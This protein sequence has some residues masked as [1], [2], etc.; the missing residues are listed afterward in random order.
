[1]IFQ[2]TAHLVTSGQKTQT[3]RLW[4]PDWDFAREW[5]IAPG[6]L[7]ICDC[8]YHRRSYWLLY[9]VGQKLAVQPGRGQRAIARI[10]V[11]RLWREDVREISDADVRAEG[12]STATDRFLSVWTHMHDKSAF[13]ELSKR[14]SFATAQ[15]YLSTRPAERYD[16]LA[17]EFRL[18]ETGDAR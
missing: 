17:I 7:M 1:V 14:E 11:L 8:V 5:W 12:F 2:H 6:K 9:Y 15:Q 13:S 10:E 18:L 3:R 4:K 16:A